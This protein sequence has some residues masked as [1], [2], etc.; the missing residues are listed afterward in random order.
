MTFLG[1]ACC[2]CTCCVAIALSFVCL[3]TSINSLHQ[4][5]FGLSY[6]YLYKTVSKTTYAPGLHLLGPFHEFVT[7]PSTLQTM[8]FSSNANDLLHART[9]D[10]LPLILGVT[11]QY[12]I[13]Q[14][15]VFDLFMNYTDGDM[16]LRYKAIYFNKASHIISE[17]ANEFT[18]YQFFNNKQTIAMELCKRLNHSFATYL[19]A[20]VVA[21]QINDD[22]LPKS[23]NDAIIESINMNQKIAQ[24]QQD[25]ENAKVTLK[26]QLETSELK[27]QATV[28][29]AKGSAEATRVKAQ[30]TASIF[31][32]TLESEAQAYG[33]IRSTLQLNSTQLLQ[34]IWWDRLENGGVGNVG[35]VDKDK[36]SQQVIFGINP[37]TYISGNGNGGS[38]ACAAGQC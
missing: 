4:T 12:R 2:I 1:K 32:Q 26:T 27:A 31:K 13:M 19:G 11:F 21:L 23:F 25:K 37:G 34:Y 16:N 22:Q 29:A 8:E 18:A 30:A 17:A 15:K 33:G 38:Q 14:N 9:N 5:Q 3:A 28:A 35:Q 24:A 7:F 20:Q 6:S 10:G 36:H